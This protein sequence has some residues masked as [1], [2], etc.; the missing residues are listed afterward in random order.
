MSEPK[1]VRSKTIKLKDIVSDAEIILRSPILGD[2]HTI[3][4]RGNMNVLY[5]GVN[6]YF[7][8]STTVADEQLKYKIVLLRDYVAILSFLSNYY[9]NQIQLTDFWSVVWEGV[10][11]DNSE[12]AQFDTR[13]DTKNCKTSFTFTFEGHRV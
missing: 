2:T 5:N 4:P 3:D 13:P 1:Y 12:I 11:V 10:I 8:R 9:G 6:K 7:R